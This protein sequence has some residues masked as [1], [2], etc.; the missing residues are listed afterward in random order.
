M[1]NEF[2]VD[3]ERGKGDKETRD[4]ENLSPFSLLPS[5]L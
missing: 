5:F 4:K 1:S 3:K 2:R